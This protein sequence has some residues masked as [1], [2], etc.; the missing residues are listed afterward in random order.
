MVRSTAGL[1]WN[2][3]R[4]ANS[5]RRGLYG[6]SNIFMVE[7]GGPSTLSVRE[8]TA[9]EGGTVEFVVTLLPASTQT[10]TVQYATSSGSAT[11]GTDYTASIG[12]LTFNAGDTSK[13]VEVSTT[14]DES[15]ET[16][17]TFTVTMS[18]AVGAAFV[19]ARATLD[20]LGTIL[21][22]DPEP[23]TEVP[24]TWPLVPSESA[25][26]G[27]F[28]LLFAS[29]TKRDATSP[30][31]GAYDAHVQDAAADGHQS[32]QDHSSRFSVL[33]STSRVDA[34]DHTGTTVTPG[35]RGVPIYWL[36]G[37]RVADDHSDFYD[38]NWS[39]NAARNESGNAAGADVEIHTGSNDDGTKH[40][41]NQLGAGGA[42]QVQVG[43]PTES[44]REIDSASAT[45]TQARGLYGL[46]KVFIVQTGGS[47]HAEC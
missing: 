12:T 9:T 35:D 39:S 41:D 29:S 21:D 37:A 31:I 4:A 25:P 27:S 33:A 3:S 19:G 10:V 15:F 44:G 16:S 20:S 36:N 17:E 6:L 22:D 38:G 43:K 34:R 32:I 13:T 8:G 45:A 47:S 2:S 11:E 26:G 23:P 18:S 7:S 46:S 28:R 1:D 42:G 5:Y 40:S 24:A 14:E 30:S